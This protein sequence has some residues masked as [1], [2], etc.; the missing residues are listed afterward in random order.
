MYVGIVSHNL[1]CCKKCADLFVVSVKSP[2]LFGNFSGTE[3]RRVSISLVPL[4]CLVLCSMR[5]IRTV[6]SATM[7][8]LQKAVVED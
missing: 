3:V 1:C 4:G 2:Y 6:V 8:S 7:V 5:V